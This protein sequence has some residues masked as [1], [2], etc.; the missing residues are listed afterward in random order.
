MEKSLI[1][2]SMDQVMHRFSYIPNI[3]QEHPKMQAGSAYKIF[4]DENGLAV[5]EW[6]HQRNMDK[7]HTSAEVLAFCCNTFLS[8]DIEQKTIIGFMEFNYR[9]SNTNNYKFR[10][11]PSY[12][13]KNGQRAAAWHD[14]A[15][16][17]YLDNDGNEDVCPGQILCFLALSDQQAD[18]ISP[19]EHVGGSYAVVRSLKDNMPTT[20]RQSQIVQRGVVDDQYHVYPCSSICG[21]VAV[22]C[23]EGVEEGNEFF[24]VGNKKHW[25]KCFHELLE[26]TDSPITE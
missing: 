8:P 17:S 6:D 21:P 13:S 5:M 26:K 15:D 22:V 19:G 16:F 20:I 9:C 10:S 24:V 12:R 4:L 18:R 23:Q 25:L 14:W 2:Q 3:R 7:A 11:H 1:K